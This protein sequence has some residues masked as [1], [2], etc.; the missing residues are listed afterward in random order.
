MLRFSNLVKHSC[1]KV[2]VC[3]N[4][5]SALTVKKASVAT[6]YGLRKPQTNDFGDD[7]APV[8]MENPYI[9][10]PSRCCLCGVHVDYKN[11]QLLSQFVSSFTGLLLPRKS[12]RTCHVFS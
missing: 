10:L 5:K 11:V 6:T 1:S 8:E 9:P 12:L 2:Q 7:D 3:C 4:V